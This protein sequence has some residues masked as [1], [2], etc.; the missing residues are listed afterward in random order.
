MSVIPGR[1]KATSPE[2]IEPLA[3]LMNGFRVCA[4]RRIPE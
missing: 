4:L 3:E 2:S 1:S